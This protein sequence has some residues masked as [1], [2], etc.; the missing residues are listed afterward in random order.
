MFIGVS[1]CKKIS[2]HNR[3]A[4]EVLPN[5][6]RAFCTMGHGCDVIPEQIRG[7]P[8]VK[9]PEYRVPVGCIF[10]T[11]EVCGRYSSTIETGKIFEAFQDPLL[12]EA[13]KY[14]DNDKIW[15]VLH[16]Y[17]QIETDE[18][19]VLRVRTEG[20][21]FTN[22][23]IS[24]WSNFDNHGYYG[25]SGIYELGK[26][27]LLK[28]G[29]IRLNDGLKMTSDELEIAKVRALKP[30][31][32]SYDRLEHVYHGSIF[33]TA[34][35]IYKG[36]STDYQYLDLMNARP[37]PGPGVYYH[38]ACRSPCDIS[39]YDPRFN[40]NTALAAA[41]SSAPN[42]SINQTKA[43]EKVKIYHDQHMIKHPVI[44]MM[45]Q[46]SMNLAKP[47]QKGQNEKYIIQKP[48]KML[49]LTDEWRSSIRNRKKRYDW[50]K[51]IIDELQK[52]I[53]IHAHPLILTIWLDDIVKVKKCCVCGGNFPLTYC[54]IED[55]YHECE[56]CYYLR[57]QQRL[58]PAALENN[59]DDPLG[60]RRQRHARMAAK[61]AVT[62]LPA[63]WL[64]SDMPE[65]REEREDRVEEREWQ[66]MTIQKIA[67][68]NKQYRMNL[69]PDFKK[70]YNMVPL[71]RGGRRM[72]RKTHR[73][74]A[75]RRTRKQTRKTTR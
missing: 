22:P 13:L 27:P 1:V 61:V 48:L 70:L 38:F 35:E 33:P 57:V 23:F 24:L 5:T 12:K 73:K 32:L 2:N 67:A 58:A 46:R 18:N 47:E 21:L 37:G 60:K 31:D 72:K 8:P 30:T 66:D 50:Y 56:N 6:R 7:E 59:V 69:E 41:T 20:Q 3:M 26:I 42:G 40:Y 10:V 29:R 4:D 65:T 49:E 74:K 52:S 11:V 34:A 63:S 51:I 43:I 64:V 62:P 55:D 15:K 44:E 45:R 36:M 16:D 68:A 9:L 28:D 19:S 71:R 53:A 17:L 39:D 75:N 54:C 25:Q 14:P